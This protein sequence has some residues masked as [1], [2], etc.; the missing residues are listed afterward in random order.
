MCET[1]PDI[2]DIYEAM[3]L[4]AAARLD[5]RMPKNLFYQQP[6]FTRREEKLFAQD[7]ERIDLRYAL[8]PETT[9][10]APYRDDVREYGDVLV[11]EIA[12]RSAA[13]RQRIAELFWQYLPR[14]Q[15][16]VFSTGERYALALALVRTNLVDR[17]RNTV[18]ETLT[19]DGLTATDDIWAQLAYPTI[20]AT[21]FYQLVRGAFDRMSVEKARRELGCNGLD[22]AAARQALARDAALAQEIAELRA[23]MKKELPFQRKAELNMRIKRIEQQRTTIHGGG[24]K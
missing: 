3:H 8:T 4:P 10:L 21:D 7:I 12:L 9:H 13:R 22:G 19:M 24:T 6:K 2:P 11:L 20:P 5:E 18:E 14:P 16:L 23:Q 1:V 15:V 17:T